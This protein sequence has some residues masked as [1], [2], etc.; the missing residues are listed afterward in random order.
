MSSK[1]KSHSKKYKR[2]KISPSK[3]RNF[4]D[5]NQPEDKEKGIIHMLYRL[6]KDLLKDNKYIVLF[7]EDYIKRLKKKC[8]VIINEKEYETGT[9]IDVKKFEKYII[10]EKLENLEVILKEEPLKD[11]SFMFAGCKSLIEVNLLSFNTQNVTN[12][13]YMFAGCENLIKLHLSTFNT[14]NVTNMS[15]MFAACKSLTEL[16]LSSFNTKNVTD[17]SCMF[18]GCKNLIKLDL[19]SFNTQNTTNIS[20]IFSGCVSLTKVNLSSFNTQ[21][22]ISMSCMFAGC[23]NL[24][25]LDLSSFNTQNITKKSYIFAGCD[26]LIKIKRKNLN[27]IKN[28][29]KLNKSKLYII[30]I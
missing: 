22:V 6:D 26:N 30:E 17:M 14:K 5:K 27:K 18:A 12:L 19:S 13:S 25:K 21:N 29:L 8:N 7:G 3:S 23:Q 9:E 16:D 4:D 1:E 20:N 10:N 28:D 15:S 11:I 2:S 24:I